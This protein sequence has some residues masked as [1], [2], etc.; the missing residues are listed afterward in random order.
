MK[1]KATKSLRKE[2]GKAATSAQANLEQ[3]LN[4]LNQ[5]NAA[6]AE[7]AARHVTRQCPNAGKAWHLLGVALLPQGKTLEAIDIL[8]KALTLLPDDAEAW[9]HYAVALNR[10]QRK[11]EA[12][13]AYKK[14]LAL[15]GNRLDTWIN[16]GKNANELEGFELAEKRL[17]KALA[18]S[19]GNP[20]ALNNLGC[21]LNGLK[22]YE[23]S[24]ACLQQSLSKQPDNPHAKIT[25]AAALSNIGLENMQDEL[26]HE[27][28]R[29]L[30]SGLAA[31]PNSIDGLFALAGAYLR[32]GELDAAMDAYRRLLD[33]AKR[34][35]NPQATLREK[36]D[37]PLGEAREALLALKAA[38]DAEG[39]PFF[40]AFGT[41]L[42]IH[43]GGDLLPFDKDLDVGLPWDT[44]RAKLE[45]A[46]QQKHG[47]TVLPH[48]VGET[49]ETCWNIGVRH[50]A[51]D[52]A[53]DLF[54]FKP[55]GG[56]LVTGFAQRPTPVTWR[57]PAF[58]CQPLD[59]QGADWNVPSPP[60]VFLE[61]MYGPNW[62]IPDSGFDGILSGHNLEASSIPV[63]R[64]F[65]FAR[66]FTHLM[67]SNFKKAASYCRQL[68]R[69]GDD[70]QIQEWLAWLETTDQ[71]SKKIQDEVATNDAP[72][73]PGLMGLHAEGRY[74]EMEKLAEAEI[75]RVGRVPR[76]LHMKGLA[77]LEQS[78]NKDALQNLEEALNGDPG[79]LNLLN[80]T[81]LSLSR[82]GRYA[83]ANQRYK[84]LLE[85]IPDDPA[86]IN[87]MASNLR[88]ARQYDEAE[89][90]LRRVLSKHPDSFAALVNLGNV[91]L[92]KVKLPDA[93][94]MLSRAVRVQSSPEALNSL[95]VAYK[96]V[97]AFDNALLHC[98]Q[99]LQLKP[100]Y[101]F[102]WA[103]RGDIL[104]GMRRYAEAAT[105]YQRA[106]QINPEHHSA[107]NGLGLALLNLGKVEETLH[108]FRI[109]MRAL[110][111]Q[112]QS[113]RARPTAKDYMDVADARGALLA[114]KDALDAE[115]IAFFLV[116]GTLLGVVR[117]GDLL[118]HDKDMDVGLA[119]DVPRDSL[120]QGLEKHGFNLLPQK[121]DVA[122]AH[123]WNISISHPKLNITIDLFFFKQEA[124]TMVTGFYHPIHPVLWRFSNFGLKTL[125]YQDRE[126]L[127]PDP[128]ESFLLDMYGPEWH[129]PDTGF[130]GVVSGY[131]RDK[132]SLDVALVYGYSRLFGRLVQEQWE[133]AMAYCRQ[134]GA[135]RP[136]PFLIELES[137]IDAVKTQEETMEKLL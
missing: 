35:R 62:R 75:E 24:A 39:V 54:F 99:A 82:I 87:N 26:Q 132:A 12:E 8:Q 80:Q 103:N 113:G 77:Q 55:E 21:A 129:I 130:D 18:L 17:R 94:E 108:A 90:L 23:E 114:L 15:D 109:G 89:N 100:D 111:R 107:L 13:E 101:Y 133:K 106:L 76:L 120:V 38:L 68:L 116:F 30:K 42:G 51:T 95:S 126:W 48:G 46:L 31:L 5:G 41:L 28:V 59:W 119:W 112:Y 63:A 16:A 50:K 14:A 52:I 7:D 9:D 45:Q 20:L 124:E 83:E 79:N 102:A 137:W 61:S 88:E 43:R 70:P 67:R 86:V 92:A 19:P 134:L 40:L 128:P 60:E 105:S 66:L 71:I 49:H 10:V 4:L 98:E 27:A 78:K 1:N 118:P 29:L 56:F 96:E 85:K 22:R 32:L 57:F 47:F 65:G 2:K 115:G 53:I 97:E 84:Q 81:A 123:E 104:L 36:P 127:V 73:L 72:D 44:P 37:M 93:I 110:C 3:I 122:V 74:E 91:L 117:D 58:S 33:A 121:F 136:D 34:Q 25:L 135:Q 125:R 131:C 64:C 6:A 11:E 69:F